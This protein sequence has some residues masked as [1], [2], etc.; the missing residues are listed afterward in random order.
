MMMRDEAL[1]LGDIAEIAEPMSV[2]AK[3]TGPSDFCSHSLAHTTHD[4]SH[5]DCLYTV[6][7]LVRWQLC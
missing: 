3:T 4:D 7:A 5:V 2:G 6:M 1:G